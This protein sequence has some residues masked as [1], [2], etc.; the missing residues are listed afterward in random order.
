MLDRSSVTKMGLIA[1]FFMSTIVGWHG[2]Q[3]RPSSMDETKHMQLAMDYHDWVLRDNPLQNPWASVY[4]PLYH[5]SIFPFMS[6]GWPTESKAVM[7]HAFY[8][9][10]FLYGVLLLGRAQGRPDDESLAAAV[11][12]L[13]YSYVLWASRRSLTDFPLMA[14]VT[15]AMGLLART[16]EFSLR[17]ASLAWGLALALAALI[18]FS[19][20]IFFLVPVIWTLSRGREASRYKNAGLGILL[21]AVVGGSWYG[22]NSAAFLSKAFGLIGE[23]TGAGVDPRTIAGASFY[24]RVWPEQ[25]GIPQTLFT[26]LGLLFAAKAL[27]RLPSRQS[28][29]LL[30]VWFVS[31]FIILSAMMNKDPRHILPGLPAIAFLAARGWNER[32]PRAWR[33]YFLW[34]SVSIL[35]G[36]TL[37]TYDRPAKENWRITEIGRYLEDHHD[38]SQPMVIASVISH[39]PRFFARTLRW[40]L[41]G[42]GYSLKTTR[43]GDGDASF[44]E[45]L[46]HREGDQ[47]SERHQLSAEWR[48]VEPETRAFQEVYPLRTTYSL[49]DQSTVRLYQRAPHP[50][51]QVSPLT[52]ESVSKRLAHTLQRWVQGPIEVSVQASSQGLREGRLSRLTASCSDCVVEGVK[53]PR[54][55]VV[56]F[57]PWLNLYRLWDEDRLGLMAL[58][59]IGASLELPAEALE[60]RLSTIKGIEAVRVE[61]QNGQVIARARWHGLSLQ[62]A[63]RLE[64]VLAGPHPHLKATLK[65]VRLAGVPLPGWVLGK[66]SRQRLWFDPQPSFPGRIL[67]SRIQLQNN[68]L[69]VE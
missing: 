51:F 25:L 62:A 68:T 54:L 43:S 10:L 57:K 14:C 69:T 5:F 59:S 63:V 39:H 32:M 17:R 64:L 46:I 50:V 60:T 24:L 48:D 27:Q 65:S 49:P 18:K 13:G 1:F 36:Y 29:G 52:T 47:G 28:D 23:V 8:L 31:S 9:L 67:L 6:I 33:P 56:L 35:F 34:A 66:A 7:A 53:V 44:V 19:F 22:W 40:T 38:T 37:W 42:Q 12:T 2:L 58:D 55:R 45:Y 16:R 3:D 41:R 11:L 61:F 26:G 20:V 15:L 30:W 21:A 4:P